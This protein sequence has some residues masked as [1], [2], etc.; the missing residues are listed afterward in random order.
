M[1]VHV[2]SMDIE[3]IKLY[4][5]LG[6]ARLRVVINYFNFLV[7]RFFCCGADCATNKQKKT[8]KRGG[9]I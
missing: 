1:F 4:D 8:K 6:A 7:M 5:Q 3:G 9:E 2:Y